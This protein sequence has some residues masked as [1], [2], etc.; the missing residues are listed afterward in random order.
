MTLENNQTIN[1]N[2]TLRFQTVNTSAYAY[3]AQQSDDNFVFYSTN[4][5]YG[6]RAIWSIFAN[7]VTSNLTVSV[8]ANFN[9]GLIVTGSATIQSSTYPYLYVNSSAVGGYKSGIQFQSSGANKFEL[10]VDISANNNNN[11]WIYDDTA[12]KVRIFIANTGFTGIGTGGPSAIFTVQGD[13]TSPSLRVLDSNTNFRFNVG[14]SY[15][16]S[17]WDG[18]ANNVAQIATSNAY[19]SWFNLTGN[20]VGIGTNTPAYTLDV[21]GN[22]RATG[23]AIIGAGIIA[24]NSIGTAGQYLT[25]NG[26]G[27]YWSSPGAVSINTAATYTWTNTHTFSNVVTFNTTVNFANGSY[28]SAAGDF[29]AQRNGNT[30]AIFLGNTGNRYLYYDGVAYNLPGAPINMSNYLAVGQS[31]TVGFAELFQGDATHTGYLSF[32]DKGPSTRYGYIGYGEFGSGTLK[33][34]SE[35]GNDL[36]LGTAGAEKLRILNANGNVGINNGSPGYQLDVYGTIHSGYGGFRTD[37]VSYPLLAYST[38]SYTPQIW[39]ENQTND[40]TGPYFQFVKSRGTSGNT[41]NSGDNFGAIQFGGR[42]NGGSGTGSN[43][44]GAYINGI[45]V[46]SANSSYLAASITVHSESYTYI[47]GAINIFRLNNY[48]EMAR[49]DGNGFYVGSTGG[50]Y[51]RTWRGVYRLDQN[52]VTQVGIINAANNASTAARFTMITGTGYSYVDWSL[53]DGAGSPYAIESYGSAVSAKY[54]QFSGTGKNF[55]FAANGNFGIGTSSPGYNLDVNGSARIT[56]GVDIQG[57][58]FVAGSYGV[59][60]VGIPGISLWYDGSGTCYMD[61]LNNGVTWLPTVLRNDALIVASSYGSEVARFT[62]SA[63]GIGT[64]S[65]SGKLEVADKI[66]THGYVTRTG[67]SGGYGGNCFNI[68]WDGTYSHLWIDNTDFGTGWPSDYRIKD[69]IKPHV[70]GALDRVMKWKPV[71]YTHKKTG[72][73]KKNDNPIIGFVA[74]ELQ[75]VTPS[76]VFGK[77]DHVDENGNMQPQSLAAIPMIAELTLALQELKAEFD[78]YKAS[79]S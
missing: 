57:G 36:V 58:L 32:Y 20:N 71:S 11:F 17:V 60:I 15:N 68:Y 33:F 43:W 59:D 49:I 8:G 1:N 28:I 37:G 7:S 18:N 55:T 3:F 16:L 24:N 74:H 70:A 77:K 62:T 75:E 34:F 13:G 41:T 29:V 10:G 51:G 72:V 50:D 9:S 61:S 45:Q 79:H 39:L 31:G 69:N 25:S 12:S 14:S 26:T 40:G 78:A 21:A 67:Y 54:T 19:Y 65:P 48:T 47:D 52:A 35:N 66:Y 4:T 27:T 46:G 42:L 2:K 30:G 23:N 5:T 22:I 73:W 38:A 56:S 44:V 64:S 53:Y 6:D 76:A 63:L